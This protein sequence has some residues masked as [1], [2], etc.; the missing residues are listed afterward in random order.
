[1]ELRGEIEFQK[2]LMNVLDDV[3]AP[4]K[5]ILCVSYNLSFDCGDCAVGINIVPQEDKL[6]VFG[7]F[8]LYIITNQ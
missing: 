3:N 7:E 5:V 4:K 2:T 1:M 6:S 8:P